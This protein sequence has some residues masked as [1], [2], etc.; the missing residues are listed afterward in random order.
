VRQIL[1]EA[2]RM[3]LVYVF[4][5][6]TSS[7]AAEFFER[8]GFEAV[9]HRAIPAAKWRDYDPERLARAHAFRVDL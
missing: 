2:R 6:T 4:A 1:E 7:P 8:N 3:R 9:P 5:V